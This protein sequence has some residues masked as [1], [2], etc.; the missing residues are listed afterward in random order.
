MLQEESD[1]TA[2]GFQYADEPENVIPLQLQEC[3]A[4]RMLQCS[5]VSNPR[6]LLDQRP[7]CGQ[8]WCS[9]GDVAELMEMLFH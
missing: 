8:V 6:S 9:P 3:L 7:S 1:P 4:W 2:L 5:S